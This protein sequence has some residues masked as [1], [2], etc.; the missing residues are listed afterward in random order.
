MPP[1]SAPERPVSHFR[2]VRAEPRLRV[3]PFALPPAAD[4]GQ[5]PAA[6]AAQAGFMRRPVAALPASRPAAAPEVRDPAPS[7]FAYRMERLWLTPLFRRFMRFGLPVLVATLAVGIYFAS[8]SR[9]AAVFAAVDR[10]RSTVENRPEFMVKL[11]AIDGASPP[12]ADAVR[13]MMPQDLPISSFRLDLGALRAS[14]ARLDAV[15]DVTVRVRGDGVLAVDITERKPAVLWRT[16]AGLDMLDPTGHRVATLLERAARPDLPVI[17]G[18]GADQAV[19]EALAI[20]AAAKPILSHVRGLVRIGDR[21]WDLVLD[22]DQRV[23]LPEDHPVQSIEEV[24]AL[25]KAEDILA[26][27]LAVID[28]R[29]ADRPTLRLATNAAAILLSK[30]Q[31][32][33]KVTGQ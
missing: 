18:E 32:D 10:V 19:P 15:G 25:D 7:R 29:N 9:R 30:T 21:R 16:A 31:P 12:V 5:K 1:L 33:T 11:M 2:S 27:D 8:D 13:A 26:R 14:I 28:L 24:I 6:R 22:R 3:G 4:Q 17:A 23:M 20:L